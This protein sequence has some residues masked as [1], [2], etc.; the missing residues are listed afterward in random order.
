MPEPD[1]FGEVTRRVSGWADRLHQRGLLRELVYP[2]SY[3]E[4]GRW[5]DGPALAAAETVF[6]AGAALAV[7]ATQT[8]VCSGWDTC[9]L[10]AWPTPAYPEK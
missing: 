1:A 2:T 8:P 4:P 9:L 10:T 5:G 3:P 7:L 6:A